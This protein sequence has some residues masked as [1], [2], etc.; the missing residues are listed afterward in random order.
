MFDAGGT[1]ERGVPTAYYVDDK[2]FGTV[3]QG[4]VFAARVAAHCTLQIHICTS[5]V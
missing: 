3:W 1:W 5:T 2:V 4:G